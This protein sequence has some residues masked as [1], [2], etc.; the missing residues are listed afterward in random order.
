MKWPGEIRA[1]LRVAG[2]C[3]ETLARGGFRLALPGNAGVLAGMASAADEDVGAPGRA[4]ICIERLRRAASD[5]KELIPPVE[6]G[7]PGASIEI[8]A[9][10]LRPQTAGMASQLETANP[11]IP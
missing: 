8:S 10:F 3:P 5:R 1:A 2:S 4:S 11:M 9:G 7:D 6:T